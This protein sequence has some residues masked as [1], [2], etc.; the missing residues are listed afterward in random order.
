MLYNNLSGYLK[1]KYGKR[2]KKICVDGGFSCPNRDGK[3]GFGGCIYCSERG[4]GE[5]I[6]GG[7]SI[8]EQVLGGLSGAGVDDGFIVYFQN[9]T[10]T[11]ADV[12]TLRARY[13]E[14]LI[15]D[16]IKILAIGTRPDCISEEIAELIASYKDK[17][18]VWVELGLQTASDK[19]AKLINRGYESSV[20]VRATEILRRYNID[21][22]THLMIGLPDEGDEELRESIDLVNKTEPFGI[23]IH[24]VYVADGTALA[25]MYRDGAYTPIEKSVYTDRVVYALTHISPK[26]IVHRIT[27]D[28]PRDMLVGKRTFEEADAW[29]D[30][31]CHTTYGDYGNAFSFLG[32]A[33]QYGKYGSVLTLDNLGK[34][35]GWEKTK[36][37]R[38]FKKHEDTYVLFRLPGAY[39]CVIFNRIYPAASEIPMPEHEDVI[40]VL[41]DIRKAGK[42]ISVRGSDS[43][44]LNCMIAWRSRIVVTAYEKE[45][46]EDANTGVALSN[47]LIRAY[48]SHGRNCKN[49]RNCIYDCR[50]MS[51]GFRRNFE[52]GHDIR[53]PCALESPFRLFT[54]GE[55][56]Y[57]KGKYF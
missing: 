53:G 33:I 18:D 14:A 1:N 19:T 44:R 23:K 6:C 8:R 36:V 30:L 28:C 39:G 57:D 29:L 24:S 17:V 46:E 21:T 3:V 31:W 45:F 35:W 55:V 52:Q 47:P 40:K 56:C 37:W 22:V 4:S 11:Y 25:K 10:N 42:K 49:C 2:L 50:G 5:H 32:P 48:F 20:Y 27:G 16:R 41:N 7:V 38:F 12:G 9:F 13:D 51:K 54:I 43:E 26:T 34:R 15:D